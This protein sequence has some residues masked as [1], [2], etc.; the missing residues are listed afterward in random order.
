MNRRLRF[1]QATSADIADAYSWYE[2]QQAGLGEE[3]R[4]ELNL[5][6]TLLSEFSEAGPAVHHNLRRLLLRRFPYAVYYRV[7]ESG[8]EVRG[9]LHLHRD[10]RAWRQRG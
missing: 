7:V 3:F 9:C 1:T 8:I 4:A 6:F 10:P 2:A 5:A